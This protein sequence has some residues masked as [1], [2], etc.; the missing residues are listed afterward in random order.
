S[1]KMLET[2]AKGFRAA[3]QKLSGVAELSDEVI[4]D[5]LRDVRM[6]LLEAD[7]EFKVTK[8]FL[9]RV[10]EAARGEQIQLKAKSKEYGVKTITPEQAFIKICQDELTAMMG[11]VDTDLRWAKKGPTGFMVV[12]LQGSGKTT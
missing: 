9:E 1:P 5:A 10:K 7:V 8:R 12:G 11:P 3:K 2:L 4:D 6:S